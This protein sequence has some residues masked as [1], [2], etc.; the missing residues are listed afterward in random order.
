MM[1]FGYLTR[2]NIHWIWGISASL[3]GQY[4]TDSLDGAVG[5]YR[6]S[7]LVKW[8]HYVDHFLDFTFLCSVVI[9]Y[10]FIAPDQAFILIAILAIFGAHYASAFL[11]F[12]LSKKFRMSASGIGMNELKIG[13]IIL[14]IC[15]IYFGT[16]YLKYLFALLAI[17][18][19][20]ALIVVVYKGQK[21]AELLDR[22]GDDYNL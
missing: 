15:I 22:N 3:V 10:A 12:G 13:L 7:G 6:D 17:S 19:L 21:E 18:A 11:L 5:R 4:I 16:S 1:L 8:G 2:Y 9:A 14:N 20:I